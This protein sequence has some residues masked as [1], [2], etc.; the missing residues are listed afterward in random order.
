MYV[1]VRVCEE[2]WATNGD[3][4][5]DTDAAASESAFSLA[6]LREQHCSPQHF[7]CDS[8]GTEAIVYIDDAHARR[9]ATERREHRCDTI[10]SDTISNARG[11]C[12]NR[13][14]YETGD[15]A[16]QTAVH[17]GDNDDDIAFANRIDA[18]Q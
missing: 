3:E 12:D 11:N 10:T 5:Y 1:R 16:W 6:F 2:K 9:A 14:I 15:N 18:S 7:D 13:R 17:A 4:A 8:R